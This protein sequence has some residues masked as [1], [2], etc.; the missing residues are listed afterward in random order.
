MK[1]M[2]LTWFHAYL[3]KVREPSACGLNGPCSV[4]NPISPEHPG[5]PLLRS[6]RDILTDTNRSLTDPR[7]KKERKNI[8]T[9]EVARVLR[10]ESDRI[11]RRIVD[12]LY[13]P[14]VHVLSL[15]T[16]RKIYK[17]NY[18]YLS[19]SII[20]ALTIDDTTVTTTTRKTVALTFTG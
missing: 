17:T 3:L 1:T 11:R 14:V 8:E 9:V 2:L 15:L 7:K 13:H 4:M 20:V 19:Q 5:P 10:P 16:Y 6:R 12:R 18:Y